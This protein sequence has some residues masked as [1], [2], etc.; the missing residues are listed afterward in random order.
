VDALGRVLGVREFTNDAKGHRSLVR[1]VSEQ[2]Q[3]R[4]IGIE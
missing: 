3:P 1:W 2:A 4:R